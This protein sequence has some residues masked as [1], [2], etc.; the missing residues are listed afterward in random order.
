M[1]IICS[2]VKMN[3]SHNIPLISFQNILNSMRGITQGRTSIFIA[4]R[5]STIVDAD[6]IMVLK[7]GRIME[8]GTHHSLLSNPDS[9]YKELWTNQNRV[10]FSTSEAMGRSG[11][12]LDGGIGGVEDDD[13]IKT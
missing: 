2:S 1:T 9:Y 7:H 6:H 11:E 4:H 10:A 12:L 8:T 3:K 5:L 13:E